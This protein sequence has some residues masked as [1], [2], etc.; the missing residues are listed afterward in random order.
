M[1][2]HGQHAPQHRQNDGPLSARPRGRRR[3]EAASARALDAALREAGV[4]ASTGPRRPR[5]GPARLPRDRAVRARRGDRRRGRAR[6]PAPRPLVGHTSGAT[7]L[8]ALGPRGRRRF[9]LHPLQTF[10]PARPGRPR[11][12]GAGCAV[13]GTDAGGARLRRRARARAGHDAVRDRRRRPRRLPRRR[14]GRLE[15][16]GHAAGG[17]RAHRRR[18]R[19][20]SRARRARCL[21]RCCDGRSTTWPSS[22]PS[23]RSPARSR[24][25]TRRRSRLSA[26]RWP[27]SRPSCSRSSTSS[28]A[29][30]ARWPSGGARHED[31]PHRRA[32][33]A[34][35]STPERRAGRA[36]GLVPTMG[37]FHDGHLSLIRRARARVRRGGGLAVRQPRAVRRGRG[38]R[39]L[40]ARRAAR[41]RRWPRP[42]GS[43]CSSPRGR[44]GLPG[45]VRHHASASAASP[46]CST[47]TPTGA[48]PSTSPASTT[49]V[50]KLFNMVGPGRRLLRPEGRPA[51]ARDPQAGAR[52]G[53]PRADRGLP[54][55]ARH[56]TGW[57]L[58]SRNAYL[59]P[60]ERERALALSRALRAAEARVAAGER[61]A[62]AVLRR[63]PGRA[64]RGRHRARVPGAALD[65]DLSPVERVNGSTLLAV[66][67][68]VGRARLID[69]TILGGTP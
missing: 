52:P 50:T 61:S 32:S 20:S 33:C 49:V 35:R 37:A 58:S 31:R 13:A 7:P 14:V 5:R 43:T 63:R 40:P 64:G 60:E 10:A 9:G 69:N 3:R 36:I 15:L 54:H 51:G 47:A 27:R 62:A 6:W 57:P 23:A 25:A 8:A 28:C 67:A 53:H 55:G 30:R 22:A 65:H 1:D 42:R 46:A 19:A 4:D 48:G 29:T 59:S 2:R 68:R 44:G 39:R 41:R 16:P 26:R 56:A 38:P 17:R 66:A 11:F 34:P 12:A 18:R 21:R 45:R 24:A